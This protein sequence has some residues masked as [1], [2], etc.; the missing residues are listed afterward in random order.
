MA[1]QYTVMWNISH[2]AKNTKRYYFEPRPLFGNFYL[3]KKLI[4]RG[5]KQ[6]IFMDPVV[7]KLVQEFDSM[8]LFRL[9]KVNLVFHNQN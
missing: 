5:K 8:C 4:K 1:H 6:N 3:K 7:A 9:K 2:Y